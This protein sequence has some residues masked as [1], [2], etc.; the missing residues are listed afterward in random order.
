[1]KEDW[2]NGNEEMQYKKVSLE[3]FKLYALQYLPDELLCGEEPEVEISVLSKFH[4][5]QVAARFIQATWG[6]DMQEKEI[7]HFSNWWEVV[8]DRWAPQWVKNRWPIKYTV[9]RMTARELYPKMSFPNQHSR[10]IVVLGGN[11]PDHMDQRMMDEAQIKWIM[12]ERA[13]HATIGEDEIVEIMDG[14]LKRMSAGEIRALSE[15]ITKRRYD[16]YGSNSR[17]ARP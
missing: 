4:T 1:M 11:V 16:D 7:R 3:K 6:R 13:K 14:L 5:D 12:K 10:S 2:V 15:E 17:F 8:K 9:E